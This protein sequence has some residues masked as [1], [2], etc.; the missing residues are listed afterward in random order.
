MKCPLLLPLILQLGGL[1]DGNEDECKREDCGWWNVEQQCC[2]V[3][4][5]ADRLAGISAN[6]AHLANKLP[7]R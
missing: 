2:S 4:V 6:L 7:P 1:P 3:E 5:I